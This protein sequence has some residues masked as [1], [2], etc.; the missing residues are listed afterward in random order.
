MQMGGD[1][2]VPF[3]SQEV[4]QAVRV[5]ATAEP[6]NDRIAGVQKSVV[7]NEFAELFDHAVMLPRYSSR[8]A[9][10]VAQ[11]LERL[12]VAQE[13]EGSRPFRRPIF[14]FVILR[15]RRYSSVSSRL[16]HSHT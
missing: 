11:G 4:Q 1:N 5:S 6:D 8:L 2:W 13:V 12:T 3:G 15:S 10:A 16:P 7:A 14:P 9:A